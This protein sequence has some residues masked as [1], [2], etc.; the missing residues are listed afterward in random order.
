MVQ[1]GVSAGSLKWLARVAVFNRECELA[2]KYL[3]LL[4]KAWFH[5]SWAEKYES[6]L[7]HAESLKNDSDYK[8]IYALQQYENTLWEDNSVVESNILNHYANLESGT[9]GMLELSMAS[10]LITKSVA[11][12]WK[13]FPVYVSQLKGKKIPV[14]VLEAALR[15]ICCWK[16][17]SQSSARSEWRSIP[18]PY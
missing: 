6:Y 10:I 8:P 3:G 4:K 11:A 7:E 15:D 9:S 5:R 18:F 2:R 14:H 17:L 16:R 1:Q 13:K 12:F